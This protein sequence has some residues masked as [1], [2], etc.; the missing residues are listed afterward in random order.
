M[1][2]S[3]LHAISIILLGKCCCVS[4][5]SVFCELS[6][7]YTTLHQWRRAASIK[8]VKSAFG[9]SGIRAALNSDFSGMKRLGVFLLPLVSGWDA[10]DGMPVH[11]R[12]TPSSLVPLQMSQNCHD[13]YIHLIKRRLVILLLQ[14]ATNHYL[15]S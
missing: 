2:L 13:L 1:Q 9:P 8:K 14:L 5:S 6:F 3:I 12:V 11:R 7:Q 15:A 4:L 10:P